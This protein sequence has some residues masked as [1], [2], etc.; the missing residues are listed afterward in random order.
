VAFADG[1]ERRGWR[2]TQGLP[3]GGRRLGEGERDQYGAC[4]VRETWEPAATLSTPTN[5]PR[6][7]GYA[8]EGNVLRDLEVALDRKVILPNA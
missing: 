7:G 1:A 8:S 2:C 6:V 5:G 3:D 4:A